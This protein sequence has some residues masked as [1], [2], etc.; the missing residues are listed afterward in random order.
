MGE[1]RFIFPSR[2]TWQAIVAMRKHCFTEDIQHQNLI[3]AKQRHVHKFYTK[4]R[5]K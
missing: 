5:S 3:P 1:T 4:T 2:T